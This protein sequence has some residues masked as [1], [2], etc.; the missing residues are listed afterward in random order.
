[1]DSSGGGGR[2]NREWRGTGAGM[3]RNGRD[4]AVFNQSREGSRGGCEA[5]TLCGAIGGWKGC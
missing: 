4:A 3:T 1:M 5:G 2:D